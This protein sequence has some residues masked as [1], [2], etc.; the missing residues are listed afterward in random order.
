MVQCELDFID[1]R[2]LAL[3]SISWYVEVECT[4]RR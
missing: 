4:Q 2:K 1:Q 3:L